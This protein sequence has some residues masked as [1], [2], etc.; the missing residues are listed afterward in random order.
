MKNSLNF[1]FRGLFITSLVI[2]FTCSESVAPDDP[3]DPNDFCDIEVCMTNGTLKQVCID[4][5]TDCVA[6]GKLSKVE[7]AAFA[8]ETCT[9]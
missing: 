2:L 6:L 9:I 4:E 8:A 5:Y 3:G 1:L 7:C